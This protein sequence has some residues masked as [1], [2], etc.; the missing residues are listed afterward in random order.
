MDSLKIKKS[1]EADINISVDEVA[2]MF[3]NMDGEQQAAFFNRIGENV[4]TW[5]AH[6]VF[7]LQSIVDTET[8]TIDG[9]QIMYEIGQYS[10]ALSVKRGKEVDEFINFLKLED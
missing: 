8:L 1:I 5:S 3:C 2:D 7:Q 10:D 6:F 9:K 4:K